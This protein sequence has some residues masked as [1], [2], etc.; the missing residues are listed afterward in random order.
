MLQKEK[1]YAPSLEE[2][3][4][5]LNLSSVST[6][7]HHVKKLQDAGYI[8]KNYNQPRSALL[9]GEIETIEIPIVGIIAAGEPIEAIENTTDKITITKDDLGKHGRHY[10]LRV[11]G[12]SMIDE[13]IFD[14]DMVII[15]DQKIADNG[16]TVV[17][18]VDDNYA[19]LKKIYKEKDRFRLQPANP[20]LLPIYKRDVEIRGVV[21]KI[22][23]NLEL[24]TE[25]IKCDS[26]LLKRRIDYSW[27]YK[28]E[29]T[30]TF[31]HGL[32]TY[33]AMFIPQVAKRLIQTYSQKGDVVCDIFCGSGTALVE[34]RLSGRN[35][36]G[37]DLNPFAV[38]LAKAKT[39]EV[40]PSKLT[41]SFFYYSIGLITL[42][43]TRS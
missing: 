16:Q 34:S 3:K 2:I 28:G 33:P 8:Y 1:N 39:T 43:L 12:S 32:H 22:I 24:P 31:T 37:I 35:S 5:H 18:I 11:E 13:G 42:S 7:H 19:T 23:R 41:K 26:A 6:A 29:K 30:K 21:V 10:A 15:R 9:A 36:V 20:N 4:E 27:D 25:E 40:D 38:F 17:A 14:G